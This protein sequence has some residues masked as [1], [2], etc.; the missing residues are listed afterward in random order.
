MNICV[1]NDGTLKLTA[2]KKVL[3]IIFKKTDAT[4]IDFSSNVRY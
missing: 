3:T 4:V 1:L 2:D